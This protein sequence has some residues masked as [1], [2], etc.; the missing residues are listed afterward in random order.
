VIN[1]RTGKEKKTQA[2]NANKEYPQMDSSSGILL[3]INYKAKNILP[4][5]ARRERR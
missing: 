1:N 2:T 3:K 4:S 5:V